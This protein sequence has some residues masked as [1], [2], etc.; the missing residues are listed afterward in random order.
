MSTFMDTGSGKPNGQPE[1]ADSQGRGHNRFIST[2]KNFFNEI[3]PFRQ[4]K[5]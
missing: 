4:N 1:G 2:L 5:S 3:N